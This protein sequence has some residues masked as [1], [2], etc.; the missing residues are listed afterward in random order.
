MKTHRIEVPNESKMVRAAADYFTEL[1]DRMEA[2]ENALR[3][4]G[5][6]DC[7]IPAQT[8]VV[9]PVGRD[10]ATDQTTPPEVGGLDDR[11]VPYNAEVHSG[12]A[13]PLG[14]N[15]A[16]KKKR[17]VDPKKLADYEAQYLNVPVTPPP[18]AVEQTLASESAQVGAPVPPPPAASAAPM[19]FKE[20]VDQI[21]A[22][23]IS[24]ATVKDTLASMGIAD[25]TALATKPESIA[26]VAAALGLG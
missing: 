8:Q 16:W 12:G 2:E 20:L 4:V 26:P 11:G 5:L 6:A 22:R 7:D 13:D 3:P 1:A 10:D 17:R 19:G 9:P 21:V 23:K 25:I 15:G 18:S 14:K 24:N